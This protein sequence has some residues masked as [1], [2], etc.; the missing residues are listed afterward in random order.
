M[1]NL[2]L[3][4]A[5]LCASVASADNYKIISM[6]HPTLLVD[7]KQA[8]VGDMVS[9]KS[10][11]TWSDDAQT[12]RLYNIKTRRQ[13]VMTA[14]KK[15]TGGIKLRELLASNRHLSTKE[16]SIDV[17]SQVVDRVKEYCQLM[18]GISG[19]AEKIEDMEKIMAM[20]ENSNVSV[21]NDLTSVRSK[22]LGDNTMPLQQYMMMLT[23]KF[24]NNVKA[25]H[26]G[27]KYLKS[28]SQP[29]PLG[30]DA[31]TYAFVKADKK[32]EAPG[33]SGASKLNILVNTSTMKVSSTISEDYEDPQGIYFQA[34]ELYNQGDLDG[35][36]P[37]FE[38][39]MDVQRFP[40]R[41]RARSMAGWIYLDRRDYHRAYDLLR[42]S[43]AA[44]PLGGVLLA[45]KILM[46]D[47]VP[48]NL[49]NY[50]EGINILQRIGET[51]DADFPQIHLIAKAAISDAM[52]NMKSFG[53]TV[54][55]KNYNFEDFIEAF[56]NDPATSPQFQCRGYILQAMKKNFNK[57]YE[58]V[59]KA[60]EAA[61]NMLDIANFSDED[62]ERMYIWIFSMRVN[63]C[64]QQGNQEKI[65]Q[66]GKELME[67]PFGASYLA[68]AML[69]GDITKE[70]MPTALDYFR[71][72]ADAGD[73]LGA[74]IMSLYYMPKHDTLRN[75]EEILMREAMWSRNHRIWKG[76][77]LFILN[78]M[79]DEDKDRHYRSAESYRKWSQLAIDR[80][81]VDAMEDRAMLEVMD[82]GLLGL[83]HDIP[84][85]V[86]MACNAAVLGMRS[87]NEKFIRTCAWA[88]G[89]EMDKGKEFEETESFKALKRLDGEGN[90]AASYILFCGYDVY[91]NDSVN[92]QYYLG[93]SKDAK[94]VKGMAD[95]A[96]RLTKTDP[97]KAFALFEEL[98]V[99][100]KTNAYYNMGVIERDIR[101]NYKNAMRYF[102]MGYKYEQ[103]WSCCESISEL[104]RN[105]LGVDVDLKKAKS[106]I[107]LASAM[108]KLQVASG[109]ADSDEAYQR[110]LRKEAEIDSLIAL[111]GGGATRVSPVERLN[112]V[113]DASLS[114]D[115]RIELSQQVLAEVFASPKA[116]VRTA[117]SNGQTIVATET[118][119]DFMLRLATLGTGKKLAEV[120]SEKNEKG[121]YKVLTVKM[122]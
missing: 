29:S 48:F 120:S 5:L 112:S 46:R 25:R 4:C 17:K 109:M 74:Y 90:G 107:S 98:T 56:L 70:Q 50:D 73:A 54:S 78:V 84:Q 49:R 12:V 57:D 43:S 65:V 105:G 103:D 101:G 108:K 34:L 116:V 79:L 68:T 85:A 33:Y 19:D 26:S 83:S 11:V 36:L 47:D 121:Q 31:V 99:Y 18:E 24:D 60:S 117:G 86:E 106:W 58:G 37:L 100:A 72:A 59:A 32:I 75:Y 51:R 35:A 53:Q 71:K 40:G 67:K 89:K 61:K 76:W 21:I 114:E 7:G 111:G 1:R 30:F 88:I 77:Q 64:Q 39:L 28:V 87:D 97:D 27:Y 110:L 81:S 44:D 63:I 20:C 122:E 16:V 82:D 41:Y 92:A 6:S 14:R 55:L 9:D 102:R 104:Y 42:E 2:F 62:Y 45:S 15:A 113:L 115:D 3:F 94:F 8:K 93:R 96:E 66:L 38:K 80:G 119:E 22:S 23:D 10:V 95:Y 91:K 69:Y 52:L 13:A 118:A